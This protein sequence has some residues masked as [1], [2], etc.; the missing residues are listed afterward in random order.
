MTLC[1]VAGQG[2][3][4][5]VLAERAR[6][7]LIAAVEGFAPEGL[8]VARSFR[9]ETLGGFIKGLKADGITRI[10][11]AGAIRRPALNPAKVDAATLPLV[12]RMLKVLGQ[13]DDAALRLVL[14]LFE[15]AGIAPV[16]AHDLVP[17]L[18]P[19]AGV[20]VGTLP[21]TAERDAARAAAIVAAMGQA[22]VGQ[23]C[24]VAGGQALAIEA[25][26]G[27]DWMLGSVA[28]ARRG[29]L[30][31]PEG[32]LLYKGPKPGQDRR[33]DLPAIGPETVRAAAEAGLR[34]VVIEAGGV[35]I[36]DRDATL[37]AAR[38]A[39]LFVWVRPA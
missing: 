28:Q 32:G 35:M 15:D 2:R 21:K 10:C 16:A 7:Q 3:L 24:V 33:V 8:E 23:A 30:R 13:G 4:P 12:P 39:G 17:D 36:V 29:D 37:E 20:L 18:L 1:L 34:G 6:P 19:P 26:P 5:Q 22:D 11:F 27:T 14:S 38:A 9:V 25:M 31:L